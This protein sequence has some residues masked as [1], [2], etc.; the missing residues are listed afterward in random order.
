[1]PLAHLAGIALLA[2][3]IACLPSMGE[4]HRNAVLGLFAY[5]AGAAILF[6][7]VGV[8]TKLGGLLLWPAAV[9]HGV[10]GAALLPLHLAP[11]V[12]GFR[13]PLCVTIRR[14]DESKISSKPILRCASPVPNHPQ[15]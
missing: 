5:N 14:V 2:L 7:W 8:A 9:L 6:T 15:R 13:R 4:S 12:L 11:E 10:I 1:M 3:G